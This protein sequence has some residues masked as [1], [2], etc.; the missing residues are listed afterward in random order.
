M[1]IQFDFM[2]FALFARAKK[3]VAE[4]ISQAPKSLAGAGWRPLIIDKA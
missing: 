2:V 4:H 3:N 1:G